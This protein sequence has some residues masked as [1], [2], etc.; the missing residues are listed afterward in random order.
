ML[1]KSPCQANHS[2]YFGSAK[3]YLSQPFS[4]I[5]GA[6]VNRGFDHV[7]A[8]FQCRVRNLE[9]GEEKGKRLKLLALNEWTIQLGRLFHTSIHRRVNGPRAARQRTGQHTLD[10]YM[11]QHL[12]FMHLGR[13][14]VCAGCRR[15]KLAFEANPGANLCKTTSSSEPARAMRATLLGSTLRKQ[16][17]ENAGRCGNNCGN[18]R[19]NHVLSGCLNVPEWAR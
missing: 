9:P 18:E 12:N 2:A 10:T 3:F 11:F 6:K 15:G 1:G 16:P 4:A 14:H 8:P 19:G 5:D 17:A 7:N 13:L